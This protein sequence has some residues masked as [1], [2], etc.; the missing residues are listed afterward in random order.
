M[1]FSSLIFLFRFLPVALLVYFI[2]PKKLKNFAIMVLSLFFYSWGEPRYFPIMIFSILVDYTVGRAI[3]AHR[4]NKGLCRLFLAISIV[5]NLGLL[6]F[7]KYTN[8]FI[9]N[10]NGLL[11]LSIQGI[12]VTLPIGISFYT[13]QTLSYSIDVYRGK[14]KAEKNIIDFGAFV[15]L[16]P[17]LIAGPIVKYTDISTALKNRRVD[18]DQIESGIELFIMGLG[19]KVLIANN[20]GALWTEVQQLGFASVSSPLAWLGVIAFTLQIYFDFSGYSLMAIGLGRILGFEFP[21]NFNHP[22]ISKSI[23]EF[24]RRWHM[25]MSFWFRDYV[26]IPLGGSRVSKPRWYFN[27]FVTWFATGL[28]HG[29]SWNFVM[30]GLYF[31]VFLIIEKA[32]LLKYLEKGKIWPHL[33]LV[34]L[35]V[36]SWAIFSI[37]DMGQLGLFFTRLFSFSPGGDWMYYLRN[38]AVTI[39][40]GIIFSTPL[41]IKLF[42]KVRHITLLRVALLGVVLIFSVAYLVDATYNPF[43]YFRF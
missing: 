14:V 43:L 36:V 17:Q 41:P 27:L 16:F 9:A 11:G 6:G 21:P 28:W 38:Y 30:W 7:F 8:F 42:E 5:C 13:F 18:L 1:V 31:L 26:Y 22:Y 4:E 35:V 32:F 33:Y 12:Q 20:I 29:A 2:T 24:W 39:G 37:E 19:K 23:T 25:T 3:E 10:L 34:F 40:A 15:T